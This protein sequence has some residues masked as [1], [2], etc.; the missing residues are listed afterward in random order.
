M[1]PLCH[2]GNSSVLWSFW[3]NNPA[4]K[5]TPSYQ[6]R[7]ERAQ[8]ITGQALTDLHESDAKVR[9]EFRTNL[10]TKVEE[11]TMKTYLFVSSDK[12]MGLVIVSCV[13]PETPELSSK[14]CVNI[15]RIG[16]S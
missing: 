6:H 13:P 11:R 12:W 2:M 7:R 14:V 9:T 1:A 8:F 16:M 3:G 15:L 4:D 5:K 10:Y